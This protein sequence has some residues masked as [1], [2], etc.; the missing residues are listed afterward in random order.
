MSKKNK[1]ILTLLS[2]N[3]NY[4]GLNT[5]IKKNDEN[6]III[7]IKESVKEHFNLNAK[8]LKLDENSIMNLMIVHS[9]EGKFKGSYIVSFHPTDGK[10]RLTLKEG[11]LKNILDSRAVVD[12]GMFKFIDL[13]GRLAQQIEYKNGKRISWGTVTT[14]EFLPKKKQDSKKKNDGVST[15]IMPVDPSLCLDFY[16]VTTYYDDFGETYEV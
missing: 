13:K 15:K 1:E 14:K 12:E 11:T 6:I 16:L 7:P 2:S 5:E 8:Y 3:L 10:K 4:D 9:K